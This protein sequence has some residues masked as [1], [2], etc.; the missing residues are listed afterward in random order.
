MA[1]LFGEVNVTAFV[2][3]QEIGNGTRP[4]TI[5]RAQD[6]SVGRAEHRHVGVRYEKRAA[7][8][9]WFE[10]SRYV[11]LERAQRADVA[12]AQCALRVGGDEVAG[13]GVADECVVH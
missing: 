13:G 10:P 12:P 8:E 9:N 11:G 6:G 1:A 3:T 2:H 4:P 7:A 5:D